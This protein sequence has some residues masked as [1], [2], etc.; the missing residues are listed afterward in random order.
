MYLL[1][2]KKI[3]LLFALGNAEENYCVTRGEFIAVVK[4][5]SHFKLYGDKFR[6]KTDHA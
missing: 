1:L 4:V 2:Y 6:I 5:V 3:F